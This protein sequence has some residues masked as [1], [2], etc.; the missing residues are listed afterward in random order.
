[1]QKQLEFYQK[2]LTTL[3]SQNNLMINKRILFTYIQDWKN[4][5]LSEKLLKNIKIEDFDKC[6]ECLVKDNWLIQD[7]N[8]KNILSINTEQIKSN[9]LDKE[10]VIFVYK[11]CKY[12]SLEMSKAYAKIY[13]QEENDIKALTKIF[14]RKDYEKNE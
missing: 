6:I 11:Y 5:N 12:E 1:M 2:F 4:L 3:V 7:K 13:N 14:R 9:Y 8:Y 10:M